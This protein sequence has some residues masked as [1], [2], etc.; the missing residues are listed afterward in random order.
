M[1]VADNRRVPPVTPS[2]FSAATALRRLADAGLVAGVLVCVHGATGI[3]VPCPLL[4]TT[5]LQCPFCG[6][7]RAAEALVRGELAMAW[8]LNAVAVVA[9]VVLGV[10]ALAWI[11]ELL[12]GLRCVRH[13]GGHDSHS[14]GFTWFSAC[15][16]ACSPWCAT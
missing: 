3:G 5:G 13:A 10:C 11:V 16:W 2:A 9:V 4:L 14:T 12:G 6:S 8:G 1:A 7:T 15:C